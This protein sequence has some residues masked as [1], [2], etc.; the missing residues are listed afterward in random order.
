MRLN[1]SIRGII[2]ALGLAALTLSACDVSPTDTSHQAGTQP[3]QTTTTSTES[4]GAT[5][6]TGVNTNPTLGTTTPTGSPDH[7][8]PTASASTGSATSTSPAGPS[9]APTPRA[10]VIVGSTQHH[11]GGKY[12]ALTFDDGPD[13][14][15]TPQ[16]LALLAQYHVQAT[17]CLIGNQAHAHT[18]L[19]R[20]IVNAGHA[21]CD[22]TMTHDEHL[23]SRSHQVKYNEINAGRQAILAAVP[24]ARVR[25]YRAPGGAFSRSTDT[26]SVQAIAVGLGM[27]PLAWSIDTVD[28]TKPGVTHIVAA[29]ES[30]GTH[31]VVL[32]H[33]AG[34][35]RSQTLD[36]LRIALP[37]LVARGY[38]F[39]LPA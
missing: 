29:I 6:T 14:T 30:A 37:W 24:S 3:A 5:S 19:V 22:H 39:D 13:P 26:D 18:E 25:Y 9:D 12:I 33:D 16:V 11:T 27:Q 17:F 2:T 35:D 7:D 31:D 1:N 36:A 15:W 34:G 32:M 4:T 8:Q 28:W 38:Q 23:P 20:A 21:L 10:D